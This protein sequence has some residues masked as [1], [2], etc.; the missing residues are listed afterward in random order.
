MCSESYVGADR[1]ATRMQS[2]GGDQC[3]GVLFG[4]VPSKENAEGCL[5]HQLVN[6]GF[7]MNYSCV[8]KLDVGISGL[9]QEQ[10][11]LGAGKN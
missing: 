1:N 11:Q 3:L 8:E 4:H 10:W 2:A 7:H 9:A 5:S 6:N